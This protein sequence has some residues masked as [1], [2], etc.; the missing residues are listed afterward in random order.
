MI[1]AKNNLKRGFTSILAL[2]ILTTGIIEVLP[3]TEVMAKPVRNGTVA[4]DTKTFEVGRDAYLAYKDGKKKLTDIIPAKSHQ[5][6]YSDDKGYTGTLKLDGVTNVS[7]GDVRKETNVK[8]TSKDSDYNWTKERRSSLGEPTKPTS[9]KTGAFPYKGTIYAK[10]PLTGKELKGTGT[11]KQF[12]RADAGKKIV[13]MTVDNGNNMYIKDKTNTRKLSGVAVRDM[14][15][16]RRLGYLSNLQKTY[17]GV[18]S[19]RDSY[20]FNYSNYPTHRN[21]NKWIYGEAM[22]Y[23]IEAG[24]TTYATIAGSSKTDLSFITRFQPGNWAG[25]VDSATKIDNDMKA[26]GIAS[27]YRKHVVKNGKFVDHDGSTYLGNKY[28]RG[29][30]VDYTFKPEQHYKYKPMYEGTVKLPKYVKTYKVTVQYKG[31]VTAPPIADLTVAPNPTD[32]NT[33]VTIDASGSKDPQ[34]SKLNYT[35]TYKKKDGNDSG[36]IVSNSPNAKHDYTFKY[37]GKYDVTVKVTNKYGKS[38]T[39]TVT[40]DNRNISPY[41]G[42]TVSDQNI[43]ANQIKQDKLDGYEVHQPIY[44]KSIAGDK[45]GHH[46]NKK[47]NVKY[48]LDVEYGSEDQAPV[49]YE[50]NA[51][52]FVIDINFLK[53]LAGSTDDVKRVKVTQEVQD[54]PQT[55]KSNYKNGDLRRTVKTIDV[56][57]VSIK[58]MVD[59]TERMKEIRELLGVTD[60]Q[61]FF[62]GEYFVLK[63]ETLAIHEFQNVKVRMIIGNPSSP[64]SDKKEWYN[65]KFEGKTTSNGTAVDK[66]SYEETDNEFWRYQD[67]MAK[68]PNNVYFEFFGTSKFGADRKDIVPVTIGEDIQTIYDLN[69][70]Y[71]NNK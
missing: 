49:R 45:D 26:K 53:G 34:N 33:S 66:W 8:G 57:N 22:D 14:T 6:P 62:N 71:G 43:P 18:V 19:P 68:N 52:N 11:F 17:P 29:L 21:L 70:A 28:R 35:I 30:Y 36:T 67:G 56:E 58:G 59:H 27:K 44:I 40:V 54:F 48:I 23:A 5:M 38:D 63:A 47:L 20:R 39:K 41:S 42:F 61:V 37:V 25:K 24:Y 9:S 2:S 51:R 64:F 1:N 69:K 16:T 4:T 7:E 3:I 50:V 60:N 32:R 10:D 65:L 15:E 12:K 31:E 55:D 13:S 46:D